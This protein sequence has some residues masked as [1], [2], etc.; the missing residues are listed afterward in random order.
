MDI[1]H[2][3]QMLEKYLEEAGMENA[4]EKYL[5]NKSDEEITIIYEAVKND[6][7]R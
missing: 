7:S 4:K 1:D 5:A 3:I 6:F 2:M